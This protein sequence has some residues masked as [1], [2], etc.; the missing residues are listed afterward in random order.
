MSSFI[1][2]VATRSY[3]NLQGN[4][5]PTFLLKHGWDIPTASFVAANSAAMELL[6]YD[7]VVMQLNDRLSSQVMR[8]A[9]ISYERYVNA[10]RH[11]DSVNFTSLTHN[12]AIIYST[13]A[14]SLFDDWSVTIQNFANI[15]RAAKR[16]GMRGIFFD[17]EEYFGKAMVYDDTNYTIEQGCSQATL[18]GRQI[19]EAI[20][21]EWSDVNIIVAHGP[22]IGED[23]TAQ[24]LRANDIPF[25]DVAW[26]NKLKASFAIGIAEATIDS[27]ARFIDGGEIYTARTAA[28]FE[29]I[30]YWQKQGVSTQGSLI[31]QHLQDKWTTAVSAS[32]G[33]YDNSGL[34]VDREMDLAAWQSTITNALSIADLYTWI[35][36]E[37]YN[38]WGTG[39]ATNLVPSE[40]IE[41]TRQAKHLNRRV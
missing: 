5:S 34:T 6:P 23:A 38:W 12:F 36:T 21:S 31:P 1:W 26:A 25:N 22:Y 4:S 17:N 37:K 15:A 16:A 10:F 28:H 2:D 14:G 30:K 39:E 13:P 20:Q 33:I 11:I 27:A 8:P 32:F 7:A 19:M 35:Y 18:R 40:W 24:Y 29:A 3:K 41:A 9:P